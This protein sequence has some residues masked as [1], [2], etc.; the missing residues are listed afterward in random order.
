MRE[1]K[2]YQ[3][4]LIE[5]EHA[6]A[7]IEKYMRDVNHFLDWLGERPLDKCAVLAFKA[8][9]QP[10]YK[11]ASANSIL[12]AVNNYL[13]FLGHPEYCVRIIRYQKNTFASQDKELTKEEYRRLLIA[14]AAD[15]RANLLMQTICSTGIRVS[16]LQF[17]TIEAVLRGQTI[18]VNKGRTRIVWLRSELTAALL[19]YAQ[20]HGIEDGPIFRS[21]NGAPLDRTRVWSIMKK[22]CEAAQVPQE[23]VYPHNLRH[24]FAR[25]HYSMEKDIVRLADILGHSCVDTTRIYTRET[26]ETHR[27]QIEKM[28]LI[29]I[30]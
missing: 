18:V 11:P 24:L 27:M 21:K 23:K 26:G 30:T 13:H 15:P 2:T 14:A 10:A 3:E 4:H 7:T 8:S 6:P 16:E 29:Y 17:I 1:L 12:S 22:Y 5:T 25:I 9:L 19:T 20:N 28:P